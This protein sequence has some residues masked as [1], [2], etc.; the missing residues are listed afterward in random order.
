MAEKGS[1]PITPELRAGLI[2]AMTKPV[3]N[4]VFCTVAERPEVTVREIADRLAIPPRSVRHHLDWLLATRLIETSS[5]STSRNTRVHHYRALVSPAVSEGDDI[6]LSGEEERELALCVLR[7]LVADARH[8]II[9]RTFGTRRGHAELRVAS[10]VDER[11]WDESSAILVRALDELMEVRES[12][13]AR[14]DASGEEGIEAI[15][16]LLLFEAKLW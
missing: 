7:M 5:E 2:A 10:R 6:E 16:A 3:R 14:L 4:T 8:A 1:S 9:N 13:A 12:S 15:S 11:G